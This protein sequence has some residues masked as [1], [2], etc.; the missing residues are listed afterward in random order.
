MHESLL[1]K[2]RPQLKLTRTVQKSYA[3]KRLHP[4]KFDR[5]I[6][7]NVPILRH[8]SRHVFLRKDSVIIAMG[9]AKVQ[10]TMKATYT[11][12]KKFEKSPIA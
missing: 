12:P 3:T 10:G 9:N 1:V 5:P 2:F 6:Q 8:R 11:F 4:W 7:E